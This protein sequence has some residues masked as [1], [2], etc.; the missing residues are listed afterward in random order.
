MFSASWYRI[1]S[2]FMVNMAAGWIGITL[3]TPAFFQ[4]PYW[5]FSLNSNIASAMVSLW[6]AQKLD[7]VS[8]Y[9]N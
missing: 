2:G 9:D 3:F 1:L 7:T 4:T 6:I 8:T 5:L